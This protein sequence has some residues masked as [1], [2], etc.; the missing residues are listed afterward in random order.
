MFSLEPFLRCVRAYAFRSQRRLSQMDIPVLSERLGPRL[1]SFIRVR[2]LLDFFPT[3]LGLSCCLHPSVYVFLE[4]SGMNL[5]PHRSMFVP[6]PVFL[7]PDEVLHLVTPGA[8]AFLS[9]NSEVCFTTYLVV[10]GVPQ[11]SSPN[12]Q[13]WYFRRRILEGAP[14][15]IYSVGAWLTLFL[16]VFF[17]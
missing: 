4:C 9:G 16:F 11:S 13:A 8:A 17:Q 15:I 10:L 14:W 1:I 6:L 12:L 2:S 3:Q 7:A 5:S